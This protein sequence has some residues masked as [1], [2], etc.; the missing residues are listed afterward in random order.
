MDIVQA[1]VISFLKTHMWDIIWIIILFALGT[2]ILRVLVNRLVR[3]AD[4]G[5]ET[6]SMRE[7]RAKT[8]GKLIV[9]SGNIIIYIIVLLMLLSL[10][11]IDLRPILA[12]VGIL[13][14]AVGFGAQ[15][16]VK[17]LV[18]GMFILVEN[19]YNVGEEVEIGGFTG[20]VKRITL[21]STVLRDKKVKKTFYIPNG[22]I[23][24][25]TNLSRK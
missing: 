23:K 12:G 19:Q 21:R 24:A 1:V 25:V 14:L 10:F 18:S 22:S 4:D 8:L 3:L 7:K 20:E 2:A 5:K 15:S 13:G 17:D 6:E 11:S 9:S 16:L